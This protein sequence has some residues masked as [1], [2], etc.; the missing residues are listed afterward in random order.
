[1]VPQVLK[2]DLSQQLEER[3]KNYFF[4]LKKFVSPLSR[5]TPAV[6]QMFDIYLSTLLFLFA[7]ALFSFILVCLHLPSYCPARH[8]TCLCNKF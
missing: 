6:F 1:M 8:N 7:L 3:L 5:K 4:I 2:K